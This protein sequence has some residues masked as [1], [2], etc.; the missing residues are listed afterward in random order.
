MVIA[1]NIR[2]P[3]VYFLPPPHVAGAGLPPL[4]VAAF[5]GFAE[6]GPLDTPVPIR[7]LE[8]YRAVFGG[9][10]VVAREAGGTTSN[11]ALAAAVAN[12]FA[13]GGRRCYVVRVCGKNA[14]ATRFRLPAI[15]ALNPGNTTQSRLVSVS[16]SSAGA[17]SK[18]LR[19]GTRLRTTPLPVS[20]FSI[21]SSRELSWSTGSAPEAIQ[22]G[23]VLRLTFDDD[24]EWLFPVSSVERSVNATPAEPVRLLASF[25]WA[26]VRT[27][28]LS[29]PPLV[30]Q[31]RR[32]M[33]TGVT[34]LDV[35]GSLAVGTGAAE[36]AGERETEFVMFG[37]DARK[38]SAGDVLQLELSDGSQCL[39]AVSASGTST[40]S[41]SP[42]ARVVISNT[43]L[44]R[45]DS[46]PLASSSPAS[47]RRVE[48]LRFDLLLRQG[49]RRLPTL[50]ELS[51]NA[52]PNRW[53]GDNLRLARL[54]E[55]G[56]AIQ[57]TRFW[58]EV[59]LFESSPLARRSAAD[60]D[61]NQAA[62][63]AR[64]FQ[65]LKTGER[66]EDAGEDDFGVT[67]LAGVLAP[68][69]ASDNIYL[70]L[71]MQS[72]S[73]EDDLVGP[74]TD[75]VGSDD[76]DSFNSDIFVDPFLVPRVDQQSLTGDALIKEAFDRYY[77][78]DKRLRG[79]H[80]LM[81]IDEVAL[82]ATPEAIHRGWKPQETQAAVFSPP[83][84]SP[85][86]S[87][88]PLLPDYAEF[89]DCEPPA[90]PPAPV[91]EPPKATEPTLPIVNDSED[92][93]L[94]T[95]LEIQH[96]M[97]TFCQARR[98]VVCILTLP[99]HF[100]KR[101]CIEWQETFRQQLGLGARRS[102]FSSESREISDLSYAAVFH[103]WLLQRDVNSANGLR[104]V[105]CDGA[106]CGMIAARERAGQVWLAPANVALQ[107]VLGLTP[108]FTKDDWAELFDLQ[109]NLVRA[110]PRDFRVMSAHTLSDEAILLQI[111]V[112]RL[113]IL[114]RKV[115]VERGMDFVFESNHQ[116]FREAV[117]LQLEEVLNFMFERGAFAGA[118]SEQSYR[119]VTDKSVN[120]PESVDAGRFIAQ[121]QVAPSQ[122]AEFITVLLTRVG[123]DLLR[124]AEA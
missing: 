51:F 71:G 79:I 113:M 89:H 92:Y 107:N 95:L 30:T 69:A 50:F 110:E 121:I 68:V 12:F 93:R 104:W 114:L 87:S 14:S 8:T 13:N 115:A 33:T 102:F 45:L 59:A 48:R 44:L 62:R 116:R 56:A 120:T 40:N 70:P 108:A 112:R 81:F 17:W 54:T 119:V 97:L 91:V 32:L 2:L 31:V 9:E 122:P 15:V 72:I 82:I 41:S 10:F 99:L 64:L 124:A 18:Q 55:L 57:P 29:P 105:A 84:T 1:S 49:K 38:I 35:N 123:E 90:V 25:A 98:D 103:P 3:G 67:A 76:L 5:V 85:P 39:F 46:A 27:E 42:A 86:I 47:L 111:S 106:A 80:S 78:Q 21:T 74:A 117:R 73:T 28:L 19:I 11:A 118:T 88:P 75:D 100:E 77:V 26:A 65:L 36:I 4:D 22:I 24:S 101:Q 52:G 66:I 109:F 53:A 63:S 37:T 83:I 34:S 7:D 6:R 16:A 58:G 43:R 61:G 94:N 60:P 23:D 20:A 96:A